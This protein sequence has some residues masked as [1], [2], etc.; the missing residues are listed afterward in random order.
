[1]QLELY[2]GA[3]DLL[4]AA[5]IFLAGAWICQLVAGALPSSKKRALILYI[6]HTLFCLIYAD[7]ILEN[8]GD[9][10]D[11]YEIAVHGLVPFSLGTDAVSYMTTLFASVMGL[12]FLGTSLI[13][14][15]L[16]ATGLIA[17]DASLKVAAADRSVTVQT[18]ARLVPFL[19]S[20]SFWSSAIGKDALAFMAVGFAL[21]AALQLRKRFWLMAFAVLLMLWVRPHIAGLM[22]L[23]LA[24][25]QLLQGSVPIT[26]RILIGGC[27]L[28]AAVVVVPFALSYVGLSAEAG[29]ADISRYI[30]QRQQ[31]NQEGGGAIDISSMSLGMQLFTYLF[32]PLPFEA[33]N[34]MMLAASIDNTLLLLLFAAAAFEAVRRRKTHLPG[35]RA[36][37]WL[38]SLMV[39][40]ILATTTANLG[41][42][43]RQKW[44]FVPVLMFLLISLIGRT[45]PRYAFML[46]ES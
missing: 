34:V 6:W 18:I 27:A 16:G 33:A 11:Y 24:A 29:P 8:R 28:A 41:L 23:A 26:R 5:V 45:R 30:E 10:V 17:F 15:I 36:F 1:M 31:Y 43:M 40:F 3:G 38:Y 19:P 22:I 42:S 44:M 14:N 4:T 2:S 9:A 13:F 32:R 20:I 37:L 35:N 46:Q 7:Y 12:S 39:W 21:W 25:S